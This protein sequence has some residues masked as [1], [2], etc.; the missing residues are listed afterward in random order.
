MY[1]Y[2]REKPKLFTE[3]G[4][5]KF[6]LIRDRVH[7]LLRDSGACTM[8]AAIRTALGDN[9]TSVACVDRLVEL[10]EIREITNGVAVQERV[11]IKRG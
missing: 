5:V 8:E 6:T 7:S 11:F 10:Q 9:W 2:N 1:D 3:E 4:S